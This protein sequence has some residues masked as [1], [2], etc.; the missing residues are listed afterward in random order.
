MMLGLSRATGMPRNV[1]HAVRTPNRH[2]ERRTARSNP[3]RRQASPI[4]PVM[5]AHAGIHALLA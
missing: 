2:C 5:P 4:Q 3:S 1:K